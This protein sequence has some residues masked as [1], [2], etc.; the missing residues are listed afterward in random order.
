MN[1]LI[2]DT[3]LTDCLNLCWVKLEDVDYMLA[4]N[5]FLRFLIPNHSRSVHRGD[6][7]Y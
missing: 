3:K 6:K 1:F 7:D 2:S 5:I 4:S